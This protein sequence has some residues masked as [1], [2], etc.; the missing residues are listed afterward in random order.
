[1]KYFLVYLHL[2]ILKTNRYVLL[3][4]STVKTKYF[5]L[6]IILTMPDN[7]RKGEGEISLGNSKITT[8]CS[9]TD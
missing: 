2:V 6:L 5:C 8:G 7:V 3:Y 1:M 4:L 9:S